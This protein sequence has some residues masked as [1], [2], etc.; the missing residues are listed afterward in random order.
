MLAAHNLVKHYKTL[1]AVDNVSLELTEGHCLGLLG[2]NGAGKTTTIE[3]LEGIVTP[4]TG[5]VLYQGNALGKAFRNQAGIM[6][7]ATALQDYIT[8]KESLVL[9]SQLYP[10]TVPLEQLI[11]TCT[12]QSFLHQD[13]RKLSGGQRQR[14]LLA[15][16]LANDPTV[17][18]LDEPTTGLDPQARRN[19]WT[20]ID[21]VK[22]QG[23]AILL[24]THYMD[25]AYQ[26]CDELVI[27]DH[28]KIIAQ[29][30]PQALLQQHFSESI[31]QLPAAALPNNITL[32]EVRLKHH[33]ERTEILTKNIDTTIKELQSQNISLAQLQIRE[34][35]L[36]DLFLEITGHELRQ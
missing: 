18:F 32:T 1:C 35:T 12:L 2:P 30:T 4:T 26:L 33:T 11:E 28:G 19:L 9:F 10:N 7:Q 20:L 34:H 21:T 8:V 31:L 5:E 24:T 27:M 29:D 22:T 14:L 6:F 3:M 13:N 15:L 25:E 16:A 17:L 36:D 23:K